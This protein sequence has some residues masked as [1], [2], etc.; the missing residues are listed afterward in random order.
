MEWQL[1]EVYESILHDGL[2]QYKFLNSKVKPMNKDNLGRNGAIFAFRSKELMNQGRGFVITSKEAVLENQSQLSHW[3]PNCYCYGRYTDTSRQFVEGHSEDNLSQINC[4]VVD[5][6]DNSM[7]VGELVLASIDKIGHSPTIITH[8]H[9]GYQ[10]FYS[11]DKPAYVTKKSNYKVVKVAKMISQNIRE[12]LAK[13]IPGVDLGCNHFGI[14]RFP[15]EENIVFF[16]KGQVSEFDSWIQ[17]SM[18]QTTDKHEDQVKKKVVMFDKK[19]YRQIDEPW[20]DLL[21]RNVKIIGQKSVLGR[22]NTLFTLALAYYS[23]KKSYTTCLYNLEQVNENFDNPLKQSELEKIIKSA[24]SEKYQG[25]SRDF[26]RE[27][28]QTW[29]SKE[30]TDKELF[31]SRKGWW[32]FKKPREQRMYSHQHEWEEDFLRYLNENSY[33]YKPYISIKKNELIEV[34]KIPKTSLDKLLKKLI[35]ENRIFMRVKKG[36]NG[37]L[38]LASVRALMATIINVRKQER[39]SFIKALQEAFGFGRRIVENILKSLQT[40]QNE[41]CQTQLFEVDVG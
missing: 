1:T 11:L 2:K 17:W 10:L 36:R 32:K 8:S 7:H 4:F 20:F 41:G 37:H 34:L 14:T 21:F 23:S 3:T 30:I 19:E 24:Y 27:L 26:I 39:E 28:C 35:K 29:I 33:T 6:D 5:I 13:E 40:S 18:K 25:A 31:V 12:A 16:D 38:V 22:N 9:S 15:N